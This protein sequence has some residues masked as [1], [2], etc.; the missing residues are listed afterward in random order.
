M[1]RRDYPLEQP[2]DEVVDPPGLAFWPDYKGRDGCRTPMVW[3][4]D[5]PHGGFT[6]GTPWL[7]VAVIGVII[8]GLVTALMGG[9]SRTV[10]QRA[11]RE[12]EHGRVLAADLMAGS[13]AEVV[14][15][16]SL[17]FLIDA[18]GIRTS[19]LL[20]GSVVVA[21]AA[22]LAVADARDTSSVTAP[23]PSVTADLP[24]S[25]PAGD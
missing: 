12:V 2:D 25:A 18:I 9:P 10:I 14:G 11:T 16:A 23:S 8:W 3:D 15:L 5:A 19:V 24:V 6:T 1:E 4:A 13:T 22:A 7:P 20:L 17:G 21:A